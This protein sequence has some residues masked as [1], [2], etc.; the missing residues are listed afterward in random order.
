M[1]VCLLTSMVGNS[2]AQAIQVPEGTLA[3]FGR[4]QPG[5][6]ASWSKGVDGSVEAEFKKEN[7]EQI[8]VYDATG[9]LLYKKMRAPLAQLP[10][11]SRG[12]LSSSGAQPSQSSAYK[13]IS[14]T[15]EKFYETWVLKTSGRECFRFALDGAQISRKE[16]PNPPDAKLASSSPASDPKIQ[17]QT[18]LGVAMRGE[19]KEM[20]AELDDE[21]GNPPLDDEQEEAD[22]EESYEDIDSLLGDEEEDLLMDEEDGEEEEDEAEEIENP[23]FRQ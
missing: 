13:V 6:Q 17:P 18:S 21:D 2:L 10:Q 5:V 11:Q 20:G 15:Q 22:E 7:T 1:W 19:K 9:A 3:A 8:Y 12:I 23:E 14:R 16:Y 4:S